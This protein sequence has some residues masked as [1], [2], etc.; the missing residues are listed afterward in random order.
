MEDRDPP[1][2][3]DAATSADTLCRIFAEH[4][5]SIC[6]KW[7]HYLPIYDAALARF[8]KR[9][10][11][12]RMLEIGVQNGGSLQIWSKYLPRNSTIVGIDIDPACAQLSL[13]PN[14]TVLIG[15][16]SDPATLDRILTN[17]H[18]D[19]II[20]DGSHR[21]KDVIATFEGCFGRLDPGGIYIIEDMHASYF[22]SHGGGF[23]IAGTSMEWVKGLL[24]A[25]NADH[26][27][28][29]A[30]EKLDAP[31]LQRLRDLGRRMKNVC[32]IAGF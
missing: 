8:A 28:S 27:Q 29:D 24:D 31:A 10:K 17:A 13:A 12:V 30:S 26:F 1:P 20:D 6:D 32:L 3:A 21:S 4:Q 18:F 23:R 15:D 14:V 16:A 25:L 9:G 5:A 19:I 2:W 22:A 7:E 11:P